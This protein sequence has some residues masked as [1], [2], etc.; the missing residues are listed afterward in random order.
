MLMA[1]GWT[2]SPVFREL[3]KVVA[4]LALFLLLA[5]VVVWVLYRYT[6]NYHQRRVQSPSIA[7][8]PYLR[9]SLPHAAPAPHLPDKTLSV[10]DVSFPASPP[11][12]PSPP[13]TGELIGQLRSIDWF[14]F[15]KVVAVAYRKTGYHVTRQG[16][17]N[18]DGGIDL[19]IE[20]EGQQTA[21]QCKQWKTWNV[22]VKAVREFLGALTDAGVQKGMF[23]TLNGYTGEAKQLADKHGIQILNETGLASLLESVAARYDPELVDI[24]NDTTKYCPKCERVMVLRMAKKGSQIGSQFWGCSDYPRCRYTMPLSQKAA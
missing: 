7:D 24:L 13:S 8:Y 18:P 20:K 16:G 11:K 15:E 12:S 1:L 21:V 10:F 17:A 6:K 3:A 9:E 22:G 4:V 5:V 19:I 23:V 2:F 14:Q